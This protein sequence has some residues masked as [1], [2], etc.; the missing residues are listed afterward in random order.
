MGIVFNNKKNINFHH[1]PDKKGYLLVANLVSYP[2][3]TLS[4]KSVPH[5][6]T[7]LTLTIGGARELSLASNTLKTE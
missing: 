4:N 1:I 7:T 6:H 3:E 2:P 5:R